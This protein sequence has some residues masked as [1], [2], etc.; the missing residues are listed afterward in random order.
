MIR[1]PTLVACLLALAATSVWGNGG[2]F[3]TSGDIGSAHHIGGVVKGS[4]TVLNVTA[5][6]DGINFTCPMKVTLVYVADNNSN[7]VVKKTL[8]LNGLSTQAMQ[9]APISAELIVVFQNQNPSH[10]CNL[11]YDL[12]SQGTVPGA[13]TSEFG[14]VDSLGDDVPAELPMPVDPAAARQ[15]GLS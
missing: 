13:L 12:D 6:Q 2:V 9:K 14:G 7:R 3:H 11:T 10:A 15:A 5:K 8:R 4:Q 1:K